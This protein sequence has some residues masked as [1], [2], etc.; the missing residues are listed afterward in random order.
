MEYKQKNVVGLLTHRRYFLI[1]DSIESA[2]SFQIPYEI[3][4]AN[5]PQKV[6]GELHVVVKEAQ[7]NGQG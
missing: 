2:H 3:L 4:A 6:A 7:T 1:F 5:V